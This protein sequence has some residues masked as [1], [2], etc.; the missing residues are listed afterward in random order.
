MPSERWFLKRNFVVIALLIVGPLALP[1]LW[2]SPGF[3][4]PAKIA[5]SVV[6]VGLSVL[7]YLMMPALLEQ[8]TQ[9]QSALPAR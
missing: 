8:I 5:L 4:R 2:F 3:K 6:F 1:L 7:S 9:I